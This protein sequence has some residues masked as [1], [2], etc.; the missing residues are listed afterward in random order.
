MDR[1]GVVRRQRLSDEVQARDADEAV[2]GEECS[3]RREAG[4]VVAVDE[5]SNRDGAT[6]GADRGGDGE[7]GI[8]PALAGATS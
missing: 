4:G 1:G 5:R 6:A 3:H 2:G 7:N 8:I